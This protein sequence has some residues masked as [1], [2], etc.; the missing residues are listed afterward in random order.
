M[1]NGDF[2]YKTQIQLQKSEI[3][4]KLS[5]VNITRSGYCV[6]REGMGAGAGLKSIKDP[7]Q[8]PL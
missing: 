2:R 7:G 8:T 6:K 3:P 5:Y 4:D 1:R